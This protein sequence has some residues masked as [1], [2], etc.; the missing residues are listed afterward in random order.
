MES[1]TAPV[2]TTFE[3]RADTSPH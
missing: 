2:K 1:S 3:C